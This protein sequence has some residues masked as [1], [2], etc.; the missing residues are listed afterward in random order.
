MFLL[1]ITPLYIC[2]R[3]DTLRN[4]I[5]K[6]QKKLKDTK[7][8]KLSA[9]ERSKRMEEAMKQE[10]RNQSKMIVEVK[11]LGEAL[12]RRNNE[13]LS[14]KN[15]ERTLDTEMQVPTGPKSSSIE[16]YRNWLQTS[17]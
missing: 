3:L 4:T 1:L 16:P 13:L 10:E 14:M 11:E 2:R 17:R 15:E 12:F 5:D 6:L 9:E 7:E 8:S